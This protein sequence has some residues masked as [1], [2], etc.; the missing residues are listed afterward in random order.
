MHISKDILK[1]LLQFR[2]P[3]CEFASYSVKYM[4]SHLLYCNK[5]PIKEEQDPLS[6]HFE[7]EAIHAESAAVK[8]EPKDLET[9]EQ[10]ESTSKFTNEVNNIEHII[11]PIEDDI[12]I[13]DE[14]ID[15]DSGESKKKPRKGHEAEV[16]KVEIESNEKQNKKCFYCENAKRWRYNSDIANSK[17]NV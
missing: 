1:Y 10:T 12:Y 11:A 2:C 13:K 3:D 9:V 5:Y 7:N 8:E 4:Q 6:T 14:P 16:L 15:K 17:K